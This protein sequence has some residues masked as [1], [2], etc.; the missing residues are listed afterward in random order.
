MKG[1]LIK[2]AFIFTY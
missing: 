1:C 2:A